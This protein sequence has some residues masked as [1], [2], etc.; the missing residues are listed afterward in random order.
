MAI[1]SSSY[2]QGNCCHTLT[3]DNTDIESQG[4]LLASIMGVSRAL[5]DHP[6]MLRWNLVPRAL[7]GLTALLCG[8]A[9]IV[10]INQIYDVQIDEVRPTVSS[11]ENLLS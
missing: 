2:N 8:N 11:I 1:C 5:L 4:T 9:Y 10:G 7:L 3:Y 6:G